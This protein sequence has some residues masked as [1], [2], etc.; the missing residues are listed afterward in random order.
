MANDKFTFNSAG[1]VHELEMAMDRA[2]GYNSVLVKK[3][4]QGD[5]LVHIREYLLGLAEVTYPEHIINCDADPFVPEGWQVEEH[6]K[7]GHF[8]W[9]SAEVQ[10][11]LSELQQ[12]GKVIGGHDLRKELASKPVLNANVLDYLL[13][14]SHLISEEWKGKYVFFWGTIYRDRSDYLCVRYLCWHSGGWDWSY[15]WLGSVWSSGSPAALRASI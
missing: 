11:Y 1:Q 12:N 14:H 7:G 8:K 4:C 9:N 13:A 2:G 3:M 10:F 6:Q 15:H 5:Y